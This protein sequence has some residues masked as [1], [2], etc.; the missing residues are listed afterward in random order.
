MSILLHQAKT[1]L[2][3]FVSSC[4]RLFEVIT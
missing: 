3:Y 2:S 1:V 4:T